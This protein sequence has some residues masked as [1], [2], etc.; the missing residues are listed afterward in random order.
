MSNRPTPWLRFLL[1]AGATLLA[2]PARAIPH[3]AALGNDGELYVVKTGTYAALFPGKEETDGSNPVLALEITRPGEP[4][5]HVLVPGTKDKDLESSPGVVFEADTETVFLFWESRSSSLSVLRL[6]SFDGTLWSPAIEV[7]GN[8]YSPKTSPQLATTRDSYEEP[9]A[10]GQPVLKHRTVLHLAWSEETAPAFYEAFYTPII[11]DEGTFIGANPLLRLN[12]FDASDDQPAS[13][14]PAALVRSPMLQAGR[15]G[16][17]VIVSFTSAVTG[18]LLALEVDVLPTQIRQLADKGRAYV[19]DLGARQKPDLPTLAAKVRELILASAGDFEPEVARSMADLL[20]GYLLGLGASPATAADY[21][22]LA[23]KVRA[24]VID[25]GAKFSGRVLKPAAGEAKSVAQ[26]L[27][28]TPRLDD[29]PENPPVHLLKV[30]TVFSRPAP[31]VGSGPVRVFVSEMATSALVS[32]TGKDRVYYRDTQGD[33]WSGVR[34]LKLTDSID[35]DRAYEVLR[36]RVQ[37]R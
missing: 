28:V 16:R 10:E 27:Q 4:P 34:E 26:I 11:L 25:L 6:A 29:M 13:A 5:V 22:A 35:L 7:A 36:Q 31:A 37:N 8:S 2:L 20:H 21:K 17:T 32:W 30:Q 23:E 3:Q 12:A 14:V 18:R 9:D 24:Y 1:F 15:E 19:I 33:G